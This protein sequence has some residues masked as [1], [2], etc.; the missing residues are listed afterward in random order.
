MCQQEKCY[1]VHTV[2]ARKSI[3]P[4]RQWCLIFWMISSDLLWTDDLNENLGVGSKGKFRRN[5][6]E[7]GAEQGRGDRVMKGELRRKLKMYISKID[8]LCVT[9]YSDHAL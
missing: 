9:S 8:N 5:V 2:M 3:Y 7:G 4:E 1:H 6:G